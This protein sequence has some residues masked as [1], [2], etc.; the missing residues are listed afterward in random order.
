MDPIE[1][2]KAGEEAKHLPIDQR[3]RLLAPCLL[4]ERT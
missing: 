2:D 4:V 1:A 3:K